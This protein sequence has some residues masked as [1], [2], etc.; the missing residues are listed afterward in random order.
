MTKTKEVILSVLS[1]IALLGIGFALGANALSGHGGGVGATVYETEH[2]V[3][4]VHNGFNDALM[5]S[6]GISVGV[7]GGNAFTSLNISTTTTLAAG[8]DC[9]YDTIVQTTSTAAITLTLPVATQ[10]T[11]TCLTQDGSHDETFIR[12]APG[13]NFAMTLATSTGDV[14]TWNPSSTI[15]A[16]L[17]TSSAGQYY[18]LEGVRYSSGLVVY[19]IGNMGIGH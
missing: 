9:S 13:N 2:F 11:A 3:G 14:L 18:R 5:M 12:V 4:E 10:T 6:N 15:G 17:A 8:Y 7:A 19:T 16:T 1:A